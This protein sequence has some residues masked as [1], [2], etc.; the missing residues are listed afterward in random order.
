M[1]FLAVLK[2]AFSLM[3]TSQS[4]QKLH[5]VC[6]QSTPPAIIH[7]LFFTLPEDI[8]LRKIAKAIPTS[9]Q[10]AGGGG[11]KKGKKGKKP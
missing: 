2:C 11:D 9:S 10:A 4:T 3:T 5:Q 1:E 8:L 7:S 6:F